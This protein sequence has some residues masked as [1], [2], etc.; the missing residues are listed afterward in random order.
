MTEATWAKAI[1]TIC[2][3]I[4][5]DPPFVLHQAI[6]HYLNEL[7]KTIRATCGF[8]DKFRNLF[9]CKFHYFICF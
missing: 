1:T 9:T 5:K 8:E 7:I 3:F 6:E 2:G 4:K